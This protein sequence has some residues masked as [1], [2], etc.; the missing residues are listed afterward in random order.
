MDAFPYIPPHLKYAGLSK[1]ERDRNAAAEKGR[2][3]TKASVTFLSQANSPGTNL[4]QADPLNTA[5]RH[6]TMST[7]SY[8]T[9]FPGGM[10]T[11]EDDDLPPFPEPEV[12]SLALDTKPGAQIHYTYYPASK[13]QGNHPNPFSQTLVVFLNGAMMPRSSWDA[14]IRSFLEKRITGRLPYPGLL[15]YD[16]YG[17]GESDPDPDDPHPPPSHGHDA[18]SA[19]KALKQFTLQIWREHLD[20]NKPTHYPCLIF[21][22]NSLGCALARLFAQCYPG[23]VSGLLFL[24][25]IIA[26][27]DYQ[28]FWPDPD[29]PDFD[30]HMLPDDV[31]ADQ[32]RAMRE[33]YRSM[34]HP[35]VPS[36]EGLSRRNLAKLLPDAGAPKLE[37]Y[38]GR[39]PYLTV[40]GHDWETFA[41]QSS[42]PPLNTPKALTMAYANPAWRRYNEELCRITEEGKAIGPITAVRCGHFIQRDDPRFV[43]DEMVSLLDRVVN[44]V[45]QVSKRD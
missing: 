21:V 38:L 40:V 35:E 12:S 17:Q 36:P 30:P 15:S 41:E 28:E 26:N 34:F 42:N 25:S 14:A 9:P 20:I 11:T 44:R 4:S 33:K 29:A 3:S 27:S 6:S 23:T 22:C 32:V 7:R 39:G 1:Q 16:R 2:D 43:S 37:G 10:E 24:D 31:T 19:V 5:R 13:P 18:I 8:P 45:Q